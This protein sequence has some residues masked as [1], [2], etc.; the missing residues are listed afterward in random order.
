MTRVTAQNLQRSFGK[1]VVLGGVDFDL[2]PV[3]MACSAAMVWA[4]R[5]Y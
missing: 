4:N 5:P 1:K 2:G 3:S